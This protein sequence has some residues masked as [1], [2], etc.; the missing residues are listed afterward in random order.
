MRAPGADRSLRA[1]SVTNNR[2]GSRRP[3]L[4]VWLVLPGV[5]LAVLMGM[6]SLEDRLSS[7]SGADERRVRRT[8]ADGG[9]VEPI[10]DS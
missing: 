6:K 3:M 5:L 8:T 4:A 9:E 7:K 10:D 2:S 1:V